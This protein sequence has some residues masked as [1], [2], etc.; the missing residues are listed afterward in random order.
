[1]G[2]WLAAADKSTKFIQ[3]NANRSI[4]H[5]ETRITRIRQ[6]SE[7]TKLFCRKMIR[8]RITR[9]T[10]TRKVQPEAAKVYRRIRRREKHAIGIGGRKGYSVKLTELR[11][12]D[13]AG[14]QKKSQHV[15]PSSCH[16]F[17]PD[18]GQ[19]MSRPPGLGITAYRQVKAKNLK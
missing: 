14:A 9:M 3:L 8:R 19:S 15:A 5:C 10:M 12:V 11:T 18:T 17:Y 6:I 2:D 1:M 4:L 13:S 16:D 7:D